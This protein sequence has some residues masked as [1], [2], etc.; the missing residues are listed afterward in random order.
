[1]TTKTGKFAIALTIFV[2]I[3]IFAIPNLLSATFVKQ[4]VADQLSQVIGRNVTIDGSSS[5]SIRPYLGVSYDNVIIS[6]PRDAVGKPLVSIDELHAR[7]GLFAALIGDAELTEVEFVRPNFQ[8]RIDQNGQQNWSLDKGHI[9][10]HV[11]NPVSSK[12]LKL[13]TIVIEDGILELT[14]ETKRQSSEL[15]AINGQI[16]WPDS[17]SAANAQMSAVWHGEIMQFSTSIAQPAA[18]LRN[19]KSEISVK[20]SSK[21]LNL[22]FDGT[23]DGTIDQYDGTLAISTPSPKRLTDWIGWRLP[24]A[25]KIGGFSASGLA[26]LH[27]YSLEFPDASVS[28]EKHKG[29]GRLQMSLRNDGSFAVNGTLAFE[30]IALPSFQDLLQSTPVNSDKPAEIDLSFL[31]GLALDVRLS[32]KIASGAPFEMN[33]LA[34]AVIVKDGRASFDIGRVETVGG[35]VS[36]SVNLQNQESSAAIT[37]D[38]VANNTDLA[39]LTQIYKATGV[40][41][42]GQG[43]VAIKLKSTG[44]N[45]DGLLLRLNGEGHI[46][47]SEGTLTGLN[48]PELYNNTIAG[49]DSVA[50]VSAGTTKY[51]ALNIGY[52]IA[53]GTAF[54]RDSYLKNQAVDVT[55]KGRVDLVRTTLALRGRINST[56]QAADKQA[57]LPFFVG[58]TAASP[59]FVPLP[60]SNNPEAIAPD[61]E[62]ASA[63]Q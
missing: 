13:G 24:A 14:D 50:R 7:L 18:W 29:M 59:L 49:S 35:T 52:F 42:Q 16:S 3:A 53:N 22:T 44:R 4:R 9:G 1:M 2:I 6:D 43:D 30:T 63:G 46:R 33:N 40:S 61:S 55:L 36:G 28:L 21:P 10:D 51:S 23:S 34:A 12:T 37:A 39:E 11:A 25:Q 47:G 27:K 17:N 38:I 26:S 45:F 41:L 56:G 19:E 32:S 15:T 20:F 48:I 8:L 62:K 5:I 31:E 60:V 58:G 54:M 57:E